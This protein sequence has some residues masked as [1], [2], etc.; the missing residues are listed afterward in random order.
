[1]IIF[2]AL[3]V[4]GLDRFT[5]LW[6]LNVLKDKESI[7]VI[8][9]FFNLTYVENRGAAFG[10]LQGNVLLLSIIS[11]IFM[12]F[13]LLMY[14][15]S[16][17]KSLL[18]RVSL[19][20]IISGAL[21]NLYDRFKYKFVVD[22]FHFHYGNTYEFPVFNVADIAVVLGTFLLM[23]YYFVIEPKESKTKN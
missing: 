17:S 12:V 20:L 23:I 18:Y 11:I 5:K 10:I 15:R 16:G 13:L 22:M 2:I 6:A 9:N 7:E 14:K 8:K 1:M 19:G 3:L 21:G 4:L